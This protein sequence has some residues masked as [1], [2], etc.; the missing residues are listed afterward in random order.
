M[1]K[2]AIT[3]LLEQFTESHKPA[4]AGVGR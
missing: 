1:G 4:L 3:E 2:P